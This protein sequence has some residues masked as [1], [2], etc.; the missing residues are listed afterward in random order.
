M[1]IERYIQIAIFVTGF[2]VG[3]ITDNKIIGRKKKSKDKDKEPK[4]L[5]TYLEGSSEDSSEDSSD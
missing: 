4:K 2:A 1:P 5:P 3:A